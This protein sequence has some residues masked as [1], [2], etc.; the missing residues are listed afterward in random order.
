MDIISVCKDSNI[1]SFSKIKVKFN[2]PLAHKPTQIRF[3][4]IINKKN[5]TNHFFSYICNGPRRNG[6]FYKLLKNKEITL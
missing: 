2:Y 3:G 5:C 6:H 1:F 4:F